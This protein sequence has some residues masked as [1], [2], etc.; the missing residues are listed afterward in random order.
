MPELRRLEGEA[1]NRHMAELA[2][3]RIRVFR[4]YPYL[5]D[6]D[7][8]YE[9]RYLQTYLQS[10]DSL[11]VMVFE[12]DH[13]VGAST[14]IPLKFETG[15]VKY[16]FVQAGMDVETIFYFGE[17]V[18]LPEYRGQGIGVAFFQHRED[19]ARQLGGYQ[20]TSFCAVDRPLDHPRR[21][22]DYQ[23]LDSFWRNRGYE[24]H[25]ELQTTFDWKE[26]GEAEESDK[27]MTFWMK[28]L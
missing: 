15:E 27:P 24:K 21:P 17:S 22:K 13:V 10:P 12:G 11:V 28:T 4:E 14:A 19:H 6:G 26:I 18:L 7:L 9:S 8:E 23:P 1:L 5:Y 20:F 2:E 25:P 3:L 16:P